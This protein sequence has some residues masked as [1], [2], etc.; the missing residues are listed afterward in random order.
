MDI[1]D[2]IDEFGRLWP[3]RPTERWIR[4]IGE[5]A[6]EVIGAFNKWD[7]GY[8]HKPKTR[9][10]V[11]EEMAQLTGCVFFTAYR[12]GVPFADFLTM[13][14]DFL[15]AKARQIREIRGMQMDHA[16]TNKY[17]PDCKKITRHFMGES[18][19]GKTFIECEECGRGK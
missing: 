16:T 2:R 5:E 12:L 17:C 8:T 1:Q 9:E 13:T 15:A 18:A 14:D 19:K 7:D 4:A 3:D 10:D 6:G 11:L